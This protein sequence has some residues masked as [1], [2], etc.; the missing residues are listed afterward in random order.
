MDQQ[1]PYTF[2]AVNLQGWRDLTFLH[3]PYAPEVV[4]ALLP[5]E[6]SVETVDGRAW[7]GVV[8]FR[9]D[10][11]RLPG[12]PP[13]PYLSSFAELN[14]R[15]YVRHANG[16]SGVWFFSLDAARLWIVAAA[17]VLGLPYMWCRGR[18]DGDASGSVRYRSDRL[19]PGRAP[20]RVRAEVEVGEPVGDADDLALFLSARWWAFSR[21]AGRL[22]QVP[23]EHPVWPLHEARAVVVDVDELVRAAG[24]PAPTGAPLVHFSP[25]V[26]TRLGL[27]RAS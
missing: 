6:L 8:P 18:V 24:L 10:R 1:G 5:E 9:M 19:L 14:C 21:R 23:V 4:Q 20:V 3:W 26:A 25:G 2:R 13:L 7:V 27:P 12:L 15:T 11:V 17:R 22:W 16:T